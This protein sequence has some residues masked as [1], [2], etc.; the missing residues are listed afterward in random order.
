MTGCPF[1]LDKGERDEIDSEVEPRLLKVSHRPHTLNDACDPKSGLVLSHLPRESS[2]GEIETS[3]TSIPKN[4]F[5][6]LFLGDNLQR[7]NLGGAANGVLRNGGLR[8]SEDI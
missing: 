3:T 1:F 7:S 8:K 5:K 4:L 6:A 2:V